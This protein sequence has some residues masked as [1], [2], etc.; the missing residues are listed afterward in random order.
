M[1]HSFHNF[2]RLLSLEIATGHFNYLDPPSSLKKTTPQLRDVS[3]NKKDDTKFK[4][5]LSLRFQL[6]SSSLTARVYFNLK[7]RVFEI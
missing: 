7:K 2:S 1:K 6:H 5:L 3:T 4:S